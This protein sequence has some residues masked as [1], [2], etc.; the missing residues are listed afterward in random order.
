LTDENILFKKLTQG[1]KI[2][3][4]ITVII[5]LFTAQLFGDEAAITEGHNEYIKESKIYGIGIKQDP[6]AGTK[7]SKGR[8]D[9]I[10][11]IWLG[12]LSRYV[13]LNTKH[14]RQII[15]IAKE[16]GDPYIYL[17]NHAEDYL[18]K[19]LECGLHTKESLDYFLESSWAMM[20]AM[21]V[22]H[23]PYLKYT[24]KDRVILAQK[25][26]DS[27]LNNHLVDNDSDS[28]KVRM[29]LIPGLA[30]ERLALHLELCTWK[31]DDAR[32]WEYEGFPIGYRMASLKRHLDSVFARH[33]DEDHIAHLLWNYMAI[34]QVCKTHPHLN[35]LPDYVA[36]IRRA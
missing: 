5:V 29:D 12:D 20:A 31:F 2:M 33:Q 6:I 32:S 16:S 21:Q 35:D 7:M 27:Y 26:Y 28:L 17:L 34:Y 13:A 11:P 22:D 10:S 30:L 8:Q 23:F 36:L 25:F 14:L 4:K 18:F 1:I 24:E 9:L 15:L 19:S 3:K